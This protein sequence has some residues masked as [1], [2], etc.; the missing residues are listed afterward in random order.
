MLRKI[1]AGSAAVGALTFGAAG[2]AGASTPTTP[3][4]SSGTNVAAVCAKLPTIESKVQAREA[5]I[6][7]LLPKV[8]A[9]E[10]KLKADGKT[11]PGQPSG[12]PGDQDSEPRDQGQRPAGQGRGQVRHDRLE[13]QLISSRSD[14]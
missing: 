7:A 13:R 1:I 8:Q 10:T 6:N 11:D 4:P 14:R 12:G 5:K 2:I 3:A 9:R